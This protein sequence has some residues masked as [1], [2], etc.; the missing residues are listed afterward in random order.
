MFGLVLMLEPAFCLTR[1]RERKAISRAAAV[2]AATAPQAIAAM[3][4]ADG[5]DRFFLV[6]LGGDGD[7]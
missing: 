7:V 3:I 1:W 2:H 5:H 6:G 4:P